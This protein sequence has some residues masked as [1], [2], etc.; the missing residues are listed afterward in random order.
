VQIHLTY[1]LMGSSEIRQQKQVFDVCELNK[2]PIGFLTSM[3]E[4]QV[5]RWIVIR[6]QF[7]VCQLI[8]ELLTEQTLTLNT[9]VTAS[10]LA[11]VRQIPSHRPGIYV[12]LK[13]QIT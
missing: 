2:D 12:E 4:L 3:I 9:I 13:L 1:E 7:Y 5:G 6:D 11:W 10:E 8:K